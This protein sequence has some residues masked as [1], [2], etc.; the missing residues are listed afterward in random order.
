MKAYKLS[1]E[2]MEML[3]K[4]C[5]ELI[6]KDETGCDTRTMLKDMYCGFYPGKTEDI[7]YLM[8]DRV[9]GYVKQYDQE[10][11][12]A[13]EDADGWFEEKVQ[14]VLS[15]KESCEDRCNTLYR[16][17]VGLTAAGLLASQGE[18]AAESYIAEHSAKAFTAEE[19]TEELETRLKEELKTAIE[20]N[21]LLA[22]VLNAYAENQAAS[23]DDTVRMVIRHGEDAL[24]F[25]AV[26][27]M[28]SYIESGEDGY[29]ADAIPA[30]AT[31]EDI[32]Y[33]ACAGVDASGIAAAVESG[34]MEES[35][36][37]RI[38]RA[39]GAVLGGIFALKVAAMVGGAIMATSVGSI[40]TFFGGIF[41]AG[42]I[43]EVIGEAS[44]E[45]GAKAAD[46]TK[47]ILCFGARCV[48]AAAR[49]VF[50]G[51]RKLVGFIG[52]FFR[53][54]NGQEDVWESFEYTEPEHE[55]K[56]EAAREVMPAPTVLA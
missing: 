9:I 8:A 29:L 17:R 36:A 23:G 49:T 11:A 4:D 53:D 24:K 12:R 28:K 35:L 56:P 18:E 10:V 51:I 13:M 22:S 5:A 14:A 15:G 47:E 43:L 45:V 31:L 25:K 50:A 40:L 20:G 37:S 26:V 55:S 48:R 27:A 46:I 44:M 7:G 3:R 19:S 6:R 52:G 32:T 34:E 1:K 39:I 54:E 16:V 21:G 33:S 42:L 30:D 41:A 38:I 2:K